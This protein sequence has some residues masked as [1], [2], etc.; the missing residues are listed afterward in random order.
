M[1]SRRAVLQAL[2]AAAQERARK[3]NFIVIL[4]DDIGY[5]DVGCFGSPDVPTPN[6]DSIAARGVRFTDGY[7]TACVCSPSRAGFM[8]GRYQQRH[9]HEFNPDPPIAREVA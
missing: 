9:G 1:V 4:A 8:T 2:A 3:P 5:G 6:I 7:V